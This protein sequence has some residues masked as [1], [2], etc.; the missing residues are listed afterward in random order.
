MP[1]TSVEELKRAVEQQHGGTASFVQFVP[2]TES[3]GDAVVW[4]GTVA[5]FD[6]ASHPKTTRA[7]AWS[8]ELDDGRRRFFAVLHLGPIAGPRDAVRA[9]IIAEQ[10]K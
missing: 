5:V 4:D 7:Y 8:Y 6:L 9:A 1:E 10:K 3:H 2:I